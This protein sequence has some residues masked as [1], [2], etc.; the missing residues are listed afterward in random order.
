MEKRYQTINAVSRDHD[1]PNEAVLRA[2]VKAGVC[3]GFYQGTRFYID[4]VL[5]REK[6][7]RE[8]VGAAEEC[9]G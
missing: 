3:P 6:L 9:C 4:K 1:F 8:S 2:M 7:D 5:L